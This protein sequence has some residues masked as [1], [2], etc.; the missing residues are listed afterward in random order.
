MTNY[1]QSNRKLKAASQPALVFNLP[2]VETCPGAGACVKYCFAAAEQ[3]RYPQARA[4]RQRSLELS[5]SAGFVPTILAELSRKRPPV[6]RVHASGDFYSWAYFLS[7]L[8]IARQ[9]EQTQFYAYTKSHWMVRR[10][11][12]LGLLPANFTAILSLGSKADA[13]VDVATER[14]ARIFESEA[15]ALAAGYTL[16]NEDDTAAW[17]ADTVKIGLV[18]FGAVA[19]WRKSV[20]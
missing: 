16:A 4:H 10:A 17:A 8:D 20:A 6:V 15:A 18:A 12:A 5:R 1:L 3:H 7:W 11:R 9:S 2:A 19:V 13:Y 14:H